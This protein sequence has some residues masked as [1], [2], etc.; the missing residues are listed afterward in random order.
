MIVLA[1]L[2]LSH[3]IYPKIPRLSLRDG[4]GRAGVAF[5]VGS[6]ALLIWNPQ[7]V[8]FPVGLTYIAVGA[9]RTAALGLLDRLPERDPLS[10]ELGVEETDARD[11]EYEEMDIRWEGGSPPL[12]GEAPEPEDE[13]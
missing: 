2:M 4:K 9:A 3:V 12:R 8:V 7:L 13:A 10:E 11:V 1:G 6:V 5:V